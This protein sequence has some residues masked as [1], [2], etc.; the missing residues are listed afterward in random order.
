MADLG[1][2][3]LSY[4]PNEHYPDEG[5]GSSSSVL[6]V[7]VDV[8][9]ETTIGDNGIFLDLFLATS[10]T[11]SDRVQIDVL[12]FG[13]T[14]RIEETTVAAYFNYASNVG[15]GSSTSFLITHNLDSR[16]IMV[17]VR[18]NTS[19][20]DQIDCAVE[21]TSTNSV[22]LTFASAP[23]TDEFRVIIVG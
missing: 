6:G 3:A 2:I 16:D 1:D 9:G 19:P 14:G 11:T 13:A 5:L 17:Q 4:Y 7:S 18:R 23:A 10:T 21:F 22:T 15:N 8:D 20:Y 12:K